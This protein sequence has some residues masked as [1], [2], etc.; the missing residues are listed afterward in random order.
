MCTNGW[1]CMYGGGAAAAW[2]H[3]GYI[4]KA[5]IQRHELKSIRTFGAQILSLLWHSLIKFQDFVLTIDTHGECKAFWAACSP[6][7]NSSPW[8]QLSIRKWFSMPQ[9]LGVNMETPSVLLPS[10]LPATLSQFLLVYFSLFS[11]CQPASSSPPKGFFCV[12]V[13]EQLIGCS[14]TAL[15]SRKLIYLGDYYIHR[16]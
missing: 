8:P 7:Q 13:F 15:S 16:S 10:F 11:C 5:A 2:R 9:R 3:I 1:N 6:N 14:L 4:G 12:L